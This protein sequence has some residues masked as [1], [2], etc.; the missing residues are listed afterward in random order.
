MPLMGVDF[1]TL[2]PG[3]QQRMHSVVS[4]FSG[5]LVFFLMTNAP[6]TR[7]LVDRIYHDMDAFLGGSATDRLVLV[8]ESSGGDAHAAY[9]LGM[10]YR[11]RAKHFTVAVPRWAKSAATLLCLAADRIIMTRIAELGP[12]DP[13]VKR[14]GETS[15]RPALYEYRAV[16]ALHDS[17]LELLGMVLDVL[18]EKTGMDTRDLIAPSLAFVAR[19]M[20]PVY[21]RID[22]AK[23]GANYSVLKVSQMYAERL[24]IAVGMS[25]ERA[26]TIAYS[27]ATWYPSHE[28]I[29]D[30]GELHRLGVAATL[31]L[32]EQEVALG[33]L[34]GLSQQFSLIGTLL[35]EDLTQRKDIPGEAERLVAAAA[36][37]DMVPS[38]QE[39][40]RGNGESTQ[41][42]ADPAPDAE[43][44]QAK[45]PRRQ[46]TG[47]PHR[48]P[49]ASPDLTADG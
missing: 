33:R 19:L 38:G 43:P 25:E 1:R 15:L 9:Q 28:F 22:P 36:E 17:S 3:V 12:L 21:G 45:R 44:V 20:A 29:L 11:G 35:P 24:L 46:P 34:A 13:Q 2:S 4:A 41:R 40:P 10:L 5:S 37:K 16:E 31:A 49:E 6:I 47:S 39:E 18:T 27:I 7:R 26:R 23:H 42:P 14:P 30:Q 48:P 8:I 32:P